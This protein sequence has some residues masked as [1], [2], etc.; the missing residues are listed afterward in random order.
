MGHWCSVRTAHSTEPPTSAE[1][2]IRAPCSS[3]HRRRVRAEPGPKTFS[4]AFW[5][6][7]TGRIPG[8]PWYS[9][10]TVLGVRET[11]VAQILVKPY[12]LDR[13]FLRMLEEHLGIA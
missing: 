8:Q 12:D 6:A 13:D 2:R 11:G 4:T 3:Y 7:A 1:F 9:A 5:M 10:R